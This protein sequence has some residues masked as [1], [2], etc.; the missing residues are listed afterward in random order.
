MKGR[1]LRASKDMRKPDLSK[2]KLAIFRKL[3]KMARLGYF[4]DCIENDAITPIIQAKPG[5]LDDLHSS[6]ITRYNQRLV[7]EFFN[8]KVH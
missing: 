8:E 4:R 5:G 3:F 1:E 7:T 6:I 2:K